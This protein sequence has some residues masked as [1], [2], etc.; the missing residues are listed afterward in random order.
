MQKK[1]MVCGLLCLLLVLTLISGCG[2]TE[3]STPP[4]S[5]P[6]TE[7]ETTEEAPT[8]SGGED[9]AEIFAKAQN[10]DG[11]YFEYEMTTGTEKVQG[12]TWT[13]GKMMKNEVFM[14]GQ[15]FINIIDID[16]GEA[17]TYIPDQNMAMK[18]KFDKQMAEEFQNPT[19]YTDNLDPQSLK[20]VETTTFDGHACTV[21]VLTNNEGQEEMKMWV[22]DEYGIPLRVETT[23]GGSQTI[24]EYKNLKVGSITDDVFE[25]PQGVQIIEMD[26]DNL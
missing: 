1:L 2:G 5:V 9:T 16:K 20:I 8:A 21:M 7:P 3:D 12:K 24:I 15:I 11:L 22:S 17:Y 13:K 10:I 26:L 14:E 23:E 6:D 19:E 4:A 25:I 18:I